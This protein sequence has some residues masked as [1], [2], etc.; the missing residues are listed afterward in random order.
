MSEADQ[1]LKIWGQLPVGE[2]YFVDGGVLD[3]KPFTTTLDAIFHRPAERRVCRHVLYLEPDPE[4]FPADQRAPRDGDRLVAPSFIAS[5]V[6]SVTRLPSYESIAD[7]LARIAEHNASIQRFDEIVQGLRNNGST[8]PSQG[9]YLTTRLLAIGQRVNAELAEALGSVEFVPKGGDARQKT[10]LTSEQIGE[11]LKKLT[12][13]IQTPPA[14]LP[15]LLT[16]LDVDFYIRRL[17]ALT[18]ELEKTTDAGSA[19]R[20]LWKHVNQEIQWLEIVRSAM[21]RVVVPYWVWNADAAFEAQLEKDPVQLWREIQL[22]TQLLLDP[23][24]LGAGPPQVNYPRA[25]ATAVERRLILEDKEKERARFREALERRLL[26]IQALDTAALGS[27]APACTLLEQCDARLATLIAASGC[28]LADF[29]DWFETREDAVRF[30]LEFAARVAQRDQINIVRLSPFDAQTAFSERALEDKLSGETFGHFGA[31]LKRS[32]RSNDILWG[33]LDGISRLVE[34]LLLHTRFGNGGAS[35]GFERLL[36]ALGSSRADRR[37]RLGE[38]FPRLQQRIGVGRKGSDALDQLLEALEAQPS[39]A[40]LT[41]ILTK[42]AQL[43]VLCEE[44][45]QVIA[46]AAEEQLEWGQRKAD[47]REPQPRAPGAGPTSAE[48]ALADQVSFWP[49]AWQFKSSAG[50][51]D[52]NVLNLATRVLAERSLAGMSPDELGQYFRHKYA[53]GAETAFLTMPVT[54]LAD[55]GARTAVLAEHALVAN[56]RI[57][58][59]IRDNGLYRLIVR[60]PIRLIAALTAFLRRSPQ[61][62]VSLVVGSLLYA[63]LALVTNLLFAGALYKGDGLGRSIAIWAFVLLPLTALVLAWVVWRSQI[64]KRLLVGGVIVAAAVAVWWRSDHIASA[65]QLP[66]VQ[67]C[68]LDSKGCH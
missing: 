66:C 47:A 1:R 18:Y 6:D 35:N 52:T 67:G 60:W 49:E 61:Y 27:E 8:L 43:D 44:L 57:G 36:G 53:V 4:R 33:R 45:P 65:L 22:R 31:F 28:P 23:D 56:G 11:V 42:I 24:Q 10:R 50:A 59:K 62:R 32:W 58:D 26:E 15:G 41:E 54:V 39:L 51:L 48:L 21:E 12:R 37:L 16:K 7:D 38:L 34:T 30:P 25:G 68:L 20:E 9:T 64:G 3:N 14:D 63:L 29:P 40:D 46:D 13:V 17:F 5:V 19:A 55:L 2:H